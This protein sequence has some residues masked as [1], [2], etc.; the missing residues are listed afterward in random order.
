MKVDRVGWDVFA[1]EDEVA[2]VGDDP[3]D[4]FALG[5]LHGLG[6]G[7]MEVDVILFADFA[8]DELDL[9]GES[10]ANISLYNWLIVSLNRVIDRTGKD[11][12]VRLSSQRPNSRAVD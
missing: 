5:E 6:D 11:R 9:G 8:A 1:G 4:G 12:P 3:L 2:L 10:H 7:G